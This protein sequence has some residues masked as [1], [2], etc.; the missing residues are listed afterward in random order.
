MPRIVLIGE[1][2]SIKEAL[3]QDLLCDIF[4][5]VSQFD[6]KAPIKT[7]HNPLFYRQTEFKKAG[8]YT[9]LL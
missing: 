6:M 5:C 4:L 9:F 7:S 8:N 2:V 3:K 1:M